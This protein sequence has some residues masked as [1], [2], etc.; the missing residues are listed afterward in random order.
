MKGKNK[1]KLIKQ[2]IETTVFFSVI[3]GS[4]ALL[5]FSKTNMQEFIIITSGLSILA[6]NAFLPDRVLWE[7]EFK[8]RCE[9]Y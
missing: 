2:F 3:F 4:T 9:K 6:L 1:R 7:I 8:K 5:I